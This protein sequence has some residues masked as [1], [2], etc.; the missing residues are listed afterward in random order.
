MRQKEGSNMLGYITLGTNDF[1]KAVA[2]YDSLLAELGGSRM[3]ESD[4]YVAWS[5]GPGSGCVVSVVKPFDGQPACIGNGVMF[6]LTTNSTDLVDTIH[7]RA[8][9]LGGTSEGEPGP[10]GDSGFYAG[11]FRD[12]DGNKLNVFFMPGME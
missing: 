7:A 1:D 5:S 12:L 4:T 3:M 10:R 6:A 2:F 8:I 11:Y 9:E